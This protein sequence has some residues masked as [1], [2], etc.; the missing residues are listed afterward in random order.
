MITFKGKMKINLG[1]TEEEILGGTE[2]KVN[3]FTGD[4]EEIK[5]F[6]DYLDIGYKSILDEVILLEESLIMSES[7]F[8]ELQYM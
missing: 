2:R 1:L 7:F 6:C 5:K 3:V 4:L 8:E